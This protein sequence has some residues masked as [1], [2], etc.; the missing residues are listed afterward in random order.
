MKLYIFSYQYISVYLFKSLHW[1]ILHKYS[2]QQ[3]MTKNKTNARQETGGSKGG[4]VVLWS[5]RNKGDT[6]L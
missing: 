1:G 3:D 5:T 2:S 6:L 4:L